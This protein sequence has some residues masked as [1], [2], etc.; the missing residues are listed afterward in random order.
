MLHDLG[1]PRH[2]RSASPDS[3]RPAARARIAHATPQCACRAQLRHGV[4]ATRAR[5]W[6][7]RVP[8]TR[9]AYPRAKEPARRRSDRTVR[10]PS[11]ATPVHRGSFRWPA[12]GEA[13]SCSPWAQAA[14]RP[15]HRPS[16]CGTYRRAAA[17]R[18]ARCPAGLRYAT[19][20]PPRPGAR[21]RA[22]RWPKRQGNATRKALEEGRRGIPRGHGEVHRA[23][24][25]R[26]LFPPRVP[27]S[28]R[29]ATDPRALVRAAPR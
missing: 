1:S 23:V 6:N 4:A 26:N 2:S 27:S 21:G 11:H 19:D 12:A 5:L 3:W 7:H 15:E 25:P 8:A 24:S 20:R 14:V 9:L 28:R 16:R 18:A 29:R 10:C 22:G 17:C 13:R